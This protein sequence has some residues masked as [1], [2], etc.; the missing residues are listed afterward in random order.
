RR[1]TAL[2]ILATPARA[3]A[4]VQAC[5]TQPTL[6]PGPAPVPEPDEELEGQ[7]PRSLFGCAG[8]A[9]GTISIDPDRLLPKATLVIHL[10]R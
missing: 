6:D 10:F 2:G 1:A 5:L 7:G 4:L 3:L 8:H 9:C